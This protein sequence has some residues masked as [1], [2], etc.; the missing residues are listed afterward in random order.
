MF[1]IELDLFSIKTTTILIHI[2]HVLKLV[3][4]PN[5]IMVELILKQFV[6]PIDVLAMKLV[7]PLD[8]VKQHLPET[9]FHLEV[10][11]MI[12]DETPTRE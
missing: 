2:E 7:I 8:I 6:V 9:F 12:I 5:I 1:T 10:G 4:I 3:Y 11:E